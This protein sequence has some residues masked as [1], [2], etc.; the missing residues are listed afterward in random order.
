MDGYEASL[1]L[2]L[3]VGGLEEDAVGRKGRRVR[4]SERE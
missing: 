1:L 3:I 2:L 4:E